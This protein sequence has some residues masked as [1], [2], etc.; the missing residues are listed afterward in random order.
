MSEYKFE[1]VCIHP[2]SSLLNYRD[3]SFESLELAMD[4]VGQMPDKE[5]AEW[6]CI[7]INKYKPLGDVAGDKSLVVG[8]KEYVKC[9]FVVKNY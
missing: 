6:K 1:V 5:K 9:W 7:L 2:D 3:D 8:D 4:Y